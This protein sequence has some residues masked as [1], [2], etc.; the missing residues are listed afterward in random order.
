MKG[1]SPFTLNLPKGVFIYDDRLFVSDT[2]NNRVLIWSKLP[3]NSNDKPDIVLGQKDFYGRKPSNAKDGLFSPVYLAF[4]GSYLWVGEFKWSDRL[5][6]FS[7]Q[8]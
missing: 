7:V 4:D 5:L 2:G 1:F 6:R 8:P 3:K